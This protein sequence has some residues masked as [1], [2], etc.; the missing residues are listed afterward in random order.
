MH[1]QVR[2]VFV[3]F[4]VFGR[5]GGHGPETLEKQAQKNSDDFRHFSSKWGVFGRVSPRTWGCSLTGPE[6]S[7]SGWLR[8]HKLGRPRGEGLSLL[9]LFTCHVPV[10][11]LKEMPTV[12]IERACKSTGGVSALMAGM[13]TSSSD[14]MQKWHED[15]PK[16]K[17]ARLTGTLNGDLRRRAVNREF[18]LVL[19]QQLAS[20]S[21]SL[22]DFLAKP[23][24]TKLEA[25]LT[26][27]VSTT[28]HAV[29]FRDG[30]GQIK[31]SFFA[32]AES[33]KERRVLLAW[34]DQGPR[35]WPC[36]S[37]LAW[38]G[39][40]VCAQGDILHRL[41]N[42]LGLAINHASLASVKLQL[43]IVLQAGSGPF[44]SGANYNVMSL[45]AQIMRKT[46]A[47]RQALFHH[48]YAH[49]AH[50]HGKDVEATFGSE[51]HQEAVFD[52]VMKLLERGGRRRQVKAS[53][54][55]S[56]EANACSLIEEVGLCTVLYLLVWVGW[57][58]GWWRTWEEC[59]LSLS[60]TAKK[61]QP[62][63]PDAAAAPDPL[64]EEAAA[65]CEPVDNQAD[66]APATASTASCSRHT[67]RLCLAAHVLSRPLLRRVFIGMAY[68]PCKVRDFFD[69]SMHQ[70]KTVWGCADLARD[71]RD[72]ALL[73]VMQHTLA[74]F[75][76]LEF[77]EKLGLDAK[78]AESFPDAENSQL[79]CTMVSLL[80][81]Y[82]S[83]LALT[84]LG[85]HYDPPCCC[86]WCLG[87]REMVQWH[88][89]T[90][91]TYTRP[92][93][94]CEPS[95]TGDVTLSAFFEICGGQRI[96]S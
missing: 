23:Q 96:S 41:H 61:M 86:D 25:T 3:I 42:D 72:G 27:H 13:E 70:L 48:M 84:S 62:Q 8:G 64:E 95:H 5:A 15:N 40:R 45:A 87:R 17:R 24:L 39:L 21:I 2:G 20:L 54:W 80:V 44:R 35:T 50:E 29:V 38:K 78:S 65:E 89:C 68:L 12:E 49:I 1:R 63:Q 67:S 81:S 52:H 10:Q 34:L 37:F 43:K 77:A 71:L 46:H 75:E 58:R 9:P 83:E 51:G 55:F 59:P 28:H 93:R 69:A 82:M 57:H 7:I 47:H 66:Q 33:W 19:E 26:V 53:R 11:V 30:S 90:W 88:L 6:L 16:R 31:H 36:M 60:S 91:R 94:P 79:A 18:V 92:M 14:L 22:F 85:Y 76:S 32:D 73:A 56:L 4:V 74:F